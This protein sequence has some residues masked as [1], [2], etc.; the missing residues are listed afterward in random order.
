LY[1]PPPD[2]LTGDPTAAPPL[3]SVGAEGCGPNTLKVIVPVAALFAPDRV[4]LIALGAIM[5]SA[6]P[7][8]GVDTLVAVVA[9]VVV[10]VTDPLP[11]FTPAFDEP[12]VIDPD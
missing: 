6:V 10:I 5:V 3:Q 4:A 8:A 12:P 9:R 1:V 11:P 2:T 7:V